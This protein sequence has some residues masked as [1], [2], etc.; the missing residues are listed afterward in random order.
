MNKRLGLLFGVSALAV[1]FTAAPV[2]AADF[3]TD[4]SN[5]TTGAD[6]DNENEFEVDTEV[7]VEAE[8]EAEV[9]NE[10]DVNAETGDNEV[11]E[12]TNAGDLTTGEIDASG[13][14]ENIAN[15]GASL[16]GA[17]DS[18]LTGS[19]DFTNEETGAD[20]DNENELD[21]D[22]EIELELENTADFWNELDFDADTGDNDIEE[23]TNVGDTETGA[24]MLTVD[25]MNEANSDSGFAG[26]DLGWLELALMGSNS[27]T[28]AD[29]DNENEFDIDSE[30][31]IEIEN[32][33]EVDNEFDVNIE[34]GDNEVERNTN[35]GDLTT[36]DGEV[37]IEATNK[38]NNGSSAMGAGSGGLELTADFSNEETGADSDNENELDVDHEVDVEIENEAEVNNEADVEID[39]GD[40][41]V[42]RNT[43]V[44]STT[45]GNATIK[46]NFSNEVNS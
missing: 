30:V 46:L 36:G 4:G 43:N 28:G 25:V 16:L 1:L 39:T 35:A 37:V 14:W 41:D 31:D 34:T 27:T 40:N 7:E 29:S 10:S 8:N 42:E 5:T 19:A 18:G 23:N 9:D 22:H 12:N 13:S 33:A 24:A 38:V 21:V 20:S 44:G 26:S 15:A 6:S 32:E 11:E 45:T 3:T 2:M 17:D